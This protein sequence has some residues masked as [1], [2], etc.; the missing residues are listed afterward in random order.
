L[1]AEIC[2]ERLSFGIAHQIRSPGIHGE[3]GQSAYLAEQLYER[4]GLTGAK[5]AEGALALMG[6]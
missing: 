3:F 6:G 5:M 4:H 1:A 2:D